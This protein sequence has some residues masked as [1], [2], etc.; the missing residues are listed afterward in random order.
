M[1]GVWYKWNGCRCRFRRAAL[2]CSTCFVR[3]TTMMTVPFLLLRQELTLGA[4]HTLVN[5]VIEL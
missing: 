2:F 5:D 4:Q 3:K 1:G